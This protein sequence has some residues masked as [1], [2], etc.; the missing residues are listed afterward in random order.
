[1]AAV[2]ERKRMK[3]RIIALA[4]CL[5]AALSLPA[6]AQQLPT[7]EPAKP[8]AEPIPRTGAKLRRV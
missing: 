5:P 6:L 3:R 7:K 4:L 1:M 8:A 2:P